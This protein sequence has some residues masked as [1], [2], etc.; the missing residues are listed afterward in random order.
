MACIQAK[1]SVQ[2]FK[3]HHIPCINKGKIM[4]IS[5]WRKCNVISIK[6][7]QYYLLLIDN[8]TKYVTLKFFK[9][10]SEAAHKI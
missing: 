2:S 1:L 6:G 8:A 5:L 7:N 4:H 9:A 3:G 10:K